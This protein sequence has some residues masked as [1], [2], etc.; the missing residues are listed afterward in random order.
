MITKLNKIFLI[1]R[2]VYWVNTAYPF[3]AAYL[4]FNGRIDLTFIL[5]C[6][7]FLIPYNLLM[8]GINDIFDYESDIRNPRKGG[9][10]GLKEQKS[11]HPLIAKSILAS[12]LLGVYLLIIGNL[13]SRLIFLFVI[14]QVVAYSIK[15]LR[16]KE[17]PLIDSFT[18]STHF[19]GPLVYA[20]SLLN[21]LNTMLPI[22][23]SFLFWG[24]ASH[25][26]GAIQDI[27]PDR[28][29]SIKSIATKLGAKFTLYFSMFC[30]LVSSIILF[31]QGGIFILVGLLPLTYLFNN[32]RF[33]KITDETSGKTNQGWRTFL[34]LNYL[35]GA[36]ITILLITNKL[37]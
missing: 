14:F 8:Y 22:I 30:Y 2:P 6:L 33:I 37:D 31:F 36:I 9:L 5:G 17:R 26:F 24:M 34:K 29:G 32:L 12:N 15:Y 18:S 35:I 3:G 16:F 23:L 4:F 11:L 28:Q 25:A 20:A 1:S 13:A 27:I 21:S 7:Y 19:V 10:E